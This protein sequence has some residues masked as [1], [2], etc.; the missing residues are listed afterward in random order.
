M[1]SQQLLSELKEIIKAEYGRDLEMSEVSQIGNGLVG[2]FDLLA[3]IKH[4]DN[5]NDNKE[6]TTKVEQ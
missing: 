5:E 6:S 1:I 2:W 4:E 3:K